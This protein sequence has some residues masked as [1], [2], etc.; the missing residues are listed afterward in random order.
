MKKILF[1]LLFA[2][3]CFTGVFA[4]VPQSF[5]Y[6]AVARD[7]N[8]NAYS[9]TNVRVRFDILQNTATGTSVYS[10]EHAVTTGFQ[11][12][13][14]L[15]IGAG[16]PI[17]G[18]FNGIDWSDG[19]YFLS[20]DFNPSASGGTF[21]HMGTTQL[22]SVPYALYAASAGN[23][24]DQQVLS[25][26][27]N[28]LS[29]SGGNSVTLSPGTTAPTLSISGTQL[30][31]SGGNTV[32]LPT[33][34][35]GAT[36]PQGPPGA[37]GPAGA[38]GPQ[39]PAG[40]DAQVLALNG[41]VLSIS[42][43]NSV[44][45]SS[46]TTAPTLSISGTQL[47]ISGGNTVTLPAGPQGPA[48]PTGPQGATGAQGPAGAA[49]PQ[50]ATGAQGAIGATGPQGATGAQGPVGPAGPQGATG[51]QGLPGATGPQGPAGNTDQY[52]EGSYINI[53]PG[54][55]PGTFIINN[56][57]PSNWSVSGNTIHNNNTGNVGIGTSTPQVDLDV[58]G[59]IRA[60][61]NLFV[62]ENVG[63][64]TLSPQYGLDVHT[65]ARVTEDFFC[66]GEIISGSVKP[67]QPN[68]FDLG[69]AN[70]RWNYLYCT[71]VQAAASGGQTAIIGIHS[72]PSGYAAEFFGNVE[73]MGNL[74]KSGGTFKI[75]HPTD[76]ANQ[77]LIHSFVES[78]DMM[79]IYNGNTTTD[80]QGF[81]TVELPAYFEAENMDFKY[82]LTCIGQ[83]AQAI[84]KQ[85]VS[86]NKFVVQTDKP[87]VEV[88]WQVT[89]VRQDAWAKANRVVPETP[90]E[91]RNKGKF[92]H[93]EL[94]GADKSQQI[95][96]KSQKS[97]PTPLGN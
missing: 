91:A 3:L 40:A 11:G 74:A 61:N 7:A 92:L 33:G 50:G 38:T 20:V 5:K 75:D 21:T 96:S 30:S 32:T 35:Q 1:M 15:Q 95:G 72:D 62:V 97:L 81:A 57:A 71:E 6:Q 49:G 63:I 2:A 43:G 78:P 8:G 46:G 55:D 19:P 34:P 88:S 22:L 73:I 65:D 53:V 42:N 27:G 51:P 87:G 59:D 31:I 14:D 68:T 36:G 52:L 79:N 9:N 58:N 89:G 70:N 28:V 90:K 45:L 4:Q 67:A 84:V 76:P 12:I 16:S 54:I 85:K 48:G 47:S 56:T 64:G 37:T 77:Y 82:Q 23:D 94:F 41:N 60:M 80:A 24:S 26:N 44:T 13:F 25:L 93:P 17:A 86:G 10:E 39:G 69:D 18:T 66:Q 29:I 83:F